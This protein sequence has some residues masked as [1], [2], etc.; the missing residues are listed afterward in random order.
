MTVATVATTSPAAVAAALA[1]FAEAAENL[2]AA[3]KADPEFAPLG[4]DA[5]VEV[6]EAVGEAVKHG[7]R[8]LL[9]DCEWAVDNLRDRLADIREER[10][11]EQRDALLGRRRG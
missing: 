3:F 2:R 9:P 11:A 1:A 10:E 5:P 6:I 4:R 7:E 8:E